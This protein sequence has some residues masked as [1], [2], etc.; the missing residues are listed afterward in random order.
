[1]PGNLVMLATDDH[2]FFR[3]FAQSV[4]AENVVQV[5]M[6]IKAARPHKED[7]HPPVRVKLAGEIIP[8]M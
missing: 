4:I 1:M 6:L 2:V 3:A 8:A 7:S 5:E